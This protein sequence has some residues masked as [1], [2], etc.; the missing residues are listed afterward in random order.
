MNRDRKKTLTTIWVLGI[1]TFFGILPIQLFCSEVLP[2]SA[3]GSYQEETALLK[4]APV[5]SIPEQPAPGPV[6]LP[7]P[8][9]VG[10]EPSAAAKPIT[11]TP[12]SPVIGI[13]TIDIE[14]GGNW[15]LKRKA[16]EDT[17][18]LIQEINGFFTKILQASTD[19]KISRNK[20]D[21][22]YDAFIMTIGFSLGDSDQLL[23]MLLQDL[24][25]EREHIG[26]LSSDE[27]AAI[28]M[29]NEKKNELEQLQADLKALGSLSDELDMVINTVDSQIK[30]ANNYQN[31]AWKN[32]Q[33]IKKVLNDEKADELYY[34]TEGLYKSMQDIYSYLTQKLSQYFTGQIQAMRDH[35]DKIKSSVQSLKQK[36]IDL[37]KNIDQMEQQDE[38]LQ[39]QRLQEEEQEAIKE[40][41]A[42][43]EMGIKKGSWFQSL[44]SVILYPFNLLKSLWSSALGWLGNLFGHPTQLSPMHTEGPEMIALKPQGDETNVAKEPGQALAD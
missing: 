2:P 16:L 38:K 7:T 11:G 33:M 12:A 28:Q 3:P 27:R 20:L 32:F 1:A 43:A 4:R 22:E 14:D 30:T 17:I 41:V 42:Q 34:Q 8:A 24:E 15:L 31:Q 36:G 18:V 29:I 19:F 35:M 6:V 37:Q 23:T 10:H 25:K 21:T 44:K 39:Q 13:D 9:A 26:D 40:A 5:P